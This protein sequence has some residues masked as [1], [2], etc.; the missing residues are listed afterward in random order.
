MQDQKHNMTRGGIPGAVRSEGW[1]PSHFT[2]KERPSVTPSPEKRK[3]P[4]W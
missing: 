4:T 1:E 2:L 3:N